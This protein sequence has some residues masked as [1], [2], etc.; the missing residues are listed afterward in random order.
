MTTDA[1]HHVTAPP[2][3]RRGLGAAR[4]AWAWGLTAVGVALQICYPLSSGVARDRLTVAIVTTLGAACVVHAGVSRGWRFAAAM[5]LGTAG[6]G[7]CVEALGVHTGVPFGAYRYSDALG[8]SVLGVPPVVAL[9]WTMIAWP[10]VLAARRLVAR[11]A[12]RIALGAWALATADLFLDPQM[13]AAGYWRWQ[14]PAPHL[15]GVPTV[16]LSN[17]A[18]WLVVAALLSLLLNTLLDRVPARSGDRVAAALYLWLW[19]GWTVALAGFL[20]LPAAASWGAVAM[21]SVAVPL[22]ARLRR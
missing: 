1:A 6:L 14:H 17:L 11:S 13:V 12:T 9:A 18:G 5:L 2:V 21:G 20:G 22:A 3:A 15:P 4:E 19:A 10:A 8:P 7:F 16:P